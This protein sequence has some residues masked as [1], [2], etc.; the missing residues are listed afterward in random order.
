MY[1]LMKFTIQFLF[2]FFISVKTFSQT[3]NP[4]IS[5]IPKPVEMQKG[6][7]HFN[8]P[9]NILIHSSA[10]PELVQTLVFLKERLS[11]PTGFHVSAAGSPENASIKLLINTLADNKLGSEGYH[12][13]VTSSHVIIRANQPAG[14]F[15][16]VQT[17]LQLLPKEIESKTL[18]KNVH[19]VIPSVEITDYPKLGW[20]GLMFDVARH[21][22]TKEEVKQYIIAM[23]RY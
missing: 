8:L 16:G 20:R 6:T 23:S 18:I 19:W 4:E 10:T 9:K 15:Y 5:I 11:I 21:F 7:G 2:C 1:N 14:L 13:S 17:L 22:F 3:F 12:L